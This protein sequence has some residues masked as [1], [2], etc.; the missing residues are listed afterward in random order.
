M[1]QYISLDQW[2]AMS[3]EERKQLAKVFGIRP[4]QGMDIVDGQVVS[5][6]VTIHDLT[7]INIGRMIEYLE[8]ES[9]EYCNQLWVMAKEKALTN[10]NQDNGIS[11]S[12]QPS[13]PK[14]GFGFSRGSR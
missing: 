2:I 8:L 12:G 4:S 10:N 11:D 3:L 1:K 14:R 6:G 13:D 9:P 7:T 5:D